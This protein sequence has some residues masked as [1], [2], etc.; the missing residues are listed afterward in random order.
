MTLT[1]GMV[2]ILTIIIV[3]MA[4]SGVVRGAGNNE[5]FGGV[6]YGIAKKFDLS[7][8]VVRVITVL[9]ALVSGGSVLLIYLLLCLALPK[10]SA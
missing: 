9:F 10:E 8:A 4:K 7:P 6:C 1:L 5:V 3:L 2:V